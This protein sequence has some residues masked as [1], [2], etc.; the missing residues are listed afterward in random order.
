MAKRRIYKNESVVVVG[1]VVTGRYILEKC[2]DITLML[3]SMT[4]R[5]KI[6]VLDLLTIWLLTEC[7]KGEDSKF[8]G[9]T[10]SL[11]KTRRV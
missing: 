1:C 7:Q 11:P 9:Y 2:R 3:D 10:D 5:G 4:W 6:D 8:S